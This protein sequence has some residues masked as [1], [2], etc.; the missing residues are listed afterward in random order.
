MRWRAAARRSAHSAPEPFFG[1]ALGAGALLLLALALLAGSALTANVTLTR[2]RDHRAEMVRSNAILRGLAELEAHI[3]RAETGQRGYILTGERRYLVPYEQAIGRIRA[4]LDR[5]RGLVRHPAQI[6]RL[7]EL[8]SLIDAELA[9]LARVVALRAQSFDAALAAMRTDLGQKLMEEIA[10]AIERM[11]AVGQEL[12]AERA[13]HEEA[14][15]A[16][17]ARMTALQGVLAMASALFGVILLARRRVQARMLDSEARLR[18][19]VDTAADG[20]LT[21]DERGTIETAN[22]AVAKLFGYAPAELIGRNV[23]VLMPEPYRTAHDG[24]LERYC[25][26]GERRVIGIG[27]EVLGLRKDGSTFPIELAV[28]ETR[29]AGKR[30][31]TGIVRDITERKRAEAALARSEAR[32]RAE[33][34]ASEARY[35]RLVDT[36]PDPILIHE[37]DGRIVYLNPAYMRLHGATRVEQLLGRPLFELVHPADHHLIREYQGRIA[38]EGGTQPPIEVRTRRLDGSEVPVEAHPT[39]ITWGERRAALVVLRDVT[40]RKQAEARQAL[41]RRELNHRVKNILAVVQSV[42]LMTGKGAETV[43]AFLQAFD[44]RLQALAGANELLVRDGWQATGL[45]AL[46]RQAL[47]P[48]GLEEGRF[49][50]RVASLPVSAALAQDLA[51]AL[52]ELATNAVKYG[53]LSVPEGRVVIEAGPVEDGTALRLVWREEGGPPVTAPAR[54]GFGTRLLGQ[55]FARQHGGSVTLDWQARGLVCRTEVPLAAAA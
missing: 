31:F 37:M 2:L 27:R 47:L 12:L 46:L 39:P 52:H 34:A 48:H 35:Q 33:L 30:L 14:S 7:Q 4:D 16:R 29:V 6:A 20:I 26:T 43:G 40:E 18:A 10:A 22:P 49:A 17:I 23:R 15:A 36:S 25:R 11:T 28:T 54:Q 42:A 32:L 41:L 53:A 44:G 24:Y 5:L 9:E 3:R 38:A 1:A 13:A 19:V 21:I 55:L 8:T 50:L 45:A 51:L